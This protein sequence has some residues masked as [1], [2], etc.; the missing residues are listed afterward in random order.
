MSFAGPTRNL[1][2]ER[3]RLQK[4][5][6]NKIARIKSINIE[7]GIIYKNLIMLGS[8]SIH[9]SETHLYRENN[10]KISEGN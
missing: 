2:R 7:P 4:S 5:V 9:P 3:I 8:K 1:D 6:A 10:K